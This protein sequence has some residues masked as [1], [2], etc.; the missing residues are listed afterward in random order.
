ME[1]AQPNSE[2]KST[3]KI[4]EKLRNTHK[5]SNM[6]EN[7]I[8][9]LNVEVKI[10]D[11]QKKGATKLPMLDEEGEIGD[12]TINC[13]GTWKMKYLESKNLGFFCQ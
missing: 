1:L 4:E 11:N 12:V 9:A 5:F 10:V 3:W 6:E 8:G 13:K 2:E 7:V